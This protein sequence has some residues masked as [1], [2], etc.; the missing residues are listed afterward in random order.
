MAVGLSL[1]V[2]IYESV[3]PQMVVL[4]R[5]PG[6]PI[7]RN[8]KQDSVGQVGDWRPSRHEEHGTRPPAPHPSACVTS[9]HD[10]LSNAH[11]LSMAC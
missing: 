2:V 8:I 7:Y 10:L 9:V 4:W 1:F 5:L 11:S 6:T 3:R